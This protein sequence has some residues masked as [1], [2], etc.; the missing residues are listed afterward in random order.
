LFAF[1]VNEAIFKENICCV[2]AVAVGHH[3]ISILMLPY[4][5]VRSARLRAAM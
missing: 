2:L 3:C 5:P 1:N 4:C